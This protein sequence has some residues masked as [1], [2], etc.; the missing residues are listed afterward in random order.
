M[1]EFV[2]IS[3]K[4]RFY[5]GVV[6]VK[7]FLWPQRRDKFSPMGIIGQSPPHSV[8]QIDWVIIFSTFRLEFLIYLLSL[9]FLGHEGF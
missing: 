9:C 4:S 6:P 5:L 3:S 8:L 2:N 7:T 1:G